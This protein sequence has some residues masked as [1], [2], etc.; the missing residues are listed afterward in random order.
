MLTRNCPTGF[1]FSTRFLIHIRGLTLWGNF[2]KELPFTRS[3]GSPRKA[4]V[5]VKSIKRGGQLHKP[6]AP[7]HLKTVIF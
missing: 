2:K 1:L 4:E 6:E 3:Y 5:R 7:A